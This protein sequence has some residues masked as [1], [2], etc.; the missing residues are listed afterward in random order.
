MLDIYYTDTV[1]IT[2]PSEVDQW[3]EPLYP[4]S[5]SV[6]C[7]FENIS[8]LIRNDRGEEVVSSAQ[9]DMA[10]N[11]GHDATITYGG[12][13]YPI[14]KIQEMKHFSVTHYVVFLQ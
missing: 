4:V 13:D 8:R 9:V 1:T 6:K 7:R 2:T 12:V 14:I 11:P 5:R 3:G 10:E